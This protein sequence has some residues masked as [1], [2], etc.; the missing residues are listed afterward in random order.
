M[1]IFLENLYQSYI[2]ILLDDVLIELSVSLSA[3]KGFL[4][5]RVELTD[6]NEVTEFTSALENISFEG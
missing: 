3:A 1:S 4:Q 2:E 5:K 6:K